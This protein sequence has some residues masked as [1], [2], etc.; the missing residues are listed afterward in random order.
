MQWMLSLPDSQ[1]MSFKERLW[2]CTTQTDEW[3][4]GM[5]PAMTNDRRSNFP[6]LAY[7]VKTYSVTLRRDRARASD[8]QDLCQGPR[9]KSRYK[10]PI[11]QQIC[12]SIAWQRWHGQYQHLPHAPARPFTQNAINSR[13][14]CPL[15]K[16]CEAA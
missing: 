4:D 16:A 10:N 14:T 6:V 5:P 2:E 9:N 3:E 7:S 15:K 13:L 8:L 12:P 11:L 1:L